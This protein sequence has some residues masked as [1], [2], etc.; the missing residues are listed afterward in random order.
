MLLCAVAIGDACFCGTSAIVML[1]QD[2]L[3]TRNSEPSSRRGLLSERFHRST[4]TIM[5]FV[6]LI[7]QEFYRWDIVAESAKMAVDVRYRLLDYINTA[8]WRQSLN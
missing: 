5:P 8:F 2:T 1:C 4:G 7:S 3:K 6:P